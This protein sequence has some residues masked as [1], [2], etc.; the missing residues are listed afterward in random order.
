MPKGVSKD[1]K[2]ISYQARRKSA[3]N[4][5]ARVNFVLKMILSGM[6]RYEIIQECMKLQTDAYK[7]SKSYLNWGVKSG[8]IIDYYNIA[9]RLLKKESKVHRGYLIGKHKRQLFDL[10][11]K[12]LD[13]KDYKNCLAIIKELNETFGLKE[14]ARLDLTT[15]GENLNKFQVEIVFGSNENTDND[16][17]SATGE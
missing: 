8:S 9:N 11:N 5:E 13:S 1:E 17:L 15:N 16:T 2:G 12:S 4:K 10:Y 6:A 3:I 7:T 14:A